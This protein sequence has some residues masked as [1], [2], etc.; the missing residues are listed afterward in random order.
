MN[1]GGSLRN[2]GVFSLVSASKAE[3]RMISSNTHRK[4]IAS[5][6]YHERKSFCPIISQGF[7]GFSSRQSFDNNTQA[8]SK[9]K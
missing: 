3:N 5:Q 1:D 8:K 7:S 4:S 9:K 2:S 6:Y